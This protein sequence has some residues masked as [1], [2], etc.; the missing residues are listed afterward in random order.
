MRIAPSVTYEVIETESD[1]EIRR[2]GHSAHIYENKMYVFGGC[3]PDWK[4]T[5]DLF[6]LHLG[7]KE[8][9]TMRTDIFF[10]RY[11]ELGTIESKWHITRYLKPF[12]NLN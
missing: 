8:A 1:E 7:K 11:L 2:Y 3:D 9:K 6:C 5:N 4:G 12:E 10:F